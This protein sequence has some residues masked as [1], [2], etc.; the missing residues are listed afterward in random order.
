MSCALVRCPGF[1][2]S[3]NNANSNRT[4]ITQ[5]AKLRRLAFIRRPY[6]PRG[7]GAAPKLYGQTL[8]R[9]H[10]LVLPN[11]GSALLPAKG[12]PHAYFTAFSAAA[13]ERFGPWLRFGSGGAAP[14]QWSKTVH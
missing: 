3:V 13:A 14:V 8:W 1:W 2:K 5:R 7:T 11:V 6:P 9:R 4:M 10:G 12:D